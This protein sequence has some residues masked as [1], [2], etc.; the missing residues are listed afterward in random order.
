MTGKLNLLVKCTCPDLCFIYVKNKSNYATISN[1]RWI[2][3]VLDEV[4]MRQSMVCFYWI[5][6]KKYF[7]IMGIIDATQMAYDKSKSGV[8][9]S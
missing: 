1:I 6:V 4:R 2:N 7:K 9:L 3:L 5:G 8:L